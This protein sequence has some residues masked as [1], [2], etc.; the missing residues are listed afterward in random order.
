M[1][2]RGPVGVIDVRASQSRAVLVREAANVAGTGLRV[3]TTDSPDTRGGPAGN[4]RAG[5]RGAARA[6]VVCVLPTRGQACPL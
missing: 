5:G 3:R 1:S 6:D 2:R 4:A